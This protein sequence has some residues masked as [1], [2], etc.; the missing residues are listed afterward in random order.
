MNWM[1]Q[2][3]STLILAATA[4]LLLVFT[5]VH[6]AGAL[7]NYS[8]LNFVSGVWLG[9]ALDAEDGVWYRPILGEAG[10]GGTRYFPGYFTLVAALSFLGMNPVL[11][12][13]LLSL[14]SGVLLLAAVYVLLR[15]LGVEPILSLAGS[16]FT[17]GSISTQFALATIRGDL[18]STALVILALAIQ[19][20]IWPMALCFA[21]AFS[22]KQTAL[23]G[24]AAAV[25]AWWLSGERSRAYK[26]AGATAVGCFAVSVL[27][28]LLSGGRVLEHM[29]SFGHGNFG[30]AG[31]LAGP[32]EAYKRIH[33]DPSMGLL[34]LL[35]VGLLLARASETWKELPSLLLLWALIVTAVVFSVPGADYNHLIDLH[36]AAVVF[37]FFQLGR[38][39]LEL[40][41]G[42]AVLAMLAVVATA[43]LAWHF[44]VWAPV[45]HRAVLDW[46]VES[47]ERIDSASGP[48]SHPIFSTDPMVPVLRGER[49]FVFDPF[50][51]SFVR[52]RRPEIQADLYRRLE[53]R[54]FPALVFD[55]DPLAEELAARNAAHFGEG[56]T[57]RLIRN[58]TLVGA[59]SGYFI[60]APR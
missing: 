44:K 20:R 2:R 54:W 48:D 50:S 35:A 30:I 4:L 39:R 42:S 21:L 11:A 49:P 55:W 34:L 19:P 12:G 29:S 24:A 7:P 5:V 56:F 57:D 26:L 53:E 41:F 32:V 6:L 36:V 31:L 47:V 46:T 14:L 18:L 59:R 3:R 37:L 22:T 40:R 33:A 9:L 10:Y 58:Y 28:V 51:F 8:R 1:P 27:T 43:H 38:G 25:L 17:L 15:R 52:H 60:F 16:L 45:D 23:Y 13:Y